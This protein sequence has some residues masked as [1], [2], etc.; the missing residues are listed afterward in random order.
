MPLQNTR[1]DAVIL[2]VFD[3]IIGRHRYGF[4]NPYTRILLDMGYQ[5][6]RQ[7]SVRDYDLLMTKNI[8][9]AEF[10]DRHAPPQLADEKRAAILQNAH[11]MFAQEKTD[12]FLNPDWP[13]FFADA[14][15]MQLK[16]ALGSNLSAPYIEVVEEYFPDVAVKGYS[17]DI[18][19]RKPQ[20]EFFHNIC[21]MMNVEPQ[22]TVMIGNS[23]ASDVRGAHHAG[24]AHAFWLASERDF[25]NNRDKMIDYP[26][27]MVVASIQHALLHINEP[28]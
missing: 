2:D 8:S 22:H 17:C 3:T 7:V 21:D 4:D 10:I 28:K 23:F 27:T 16:V 9:F 18:G 12:F 24:F 14:Q 11:D 25:T 13:E 20:P 19:A 5:H 1:I 26:D 15:N 6:P